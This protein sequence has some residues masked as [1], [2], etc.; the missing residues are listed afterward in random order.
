MV[1]SFNLTYLNLV[2]W[3]QLVCLITLLWCV[4]YLLRAYWCFNTSLLEDE[5]FRSTFVDFTKAQT[6]IVYFLCHE[7]HNCITLSVRKWYPGAWK[8]FGGMGS[9]S[10]GKR[11]HSLSYWVSG[12][13]GCWCAPDSTAS[14][15]WMH[16]Q[17]SSS[18]YKGKMVRAGQCTLWRLSLVSCLSR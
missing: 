17:S 3:C 2:T 4:A 14:L 1:H 6:K 8:V 13:R 9:F 18:S 12:H 5:H 15:W 10:R 16:L 11:T 7:R